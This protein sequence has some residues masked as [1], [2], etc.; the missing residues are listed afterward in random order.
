[1]KKYLPIFLLLLAQAVVGQTTFMKLYQKNGQIIKLP[2]N[3]IDSSTFAVES[4]VSLPNLFTW[5]VENIGFESA[6][7]GGVIFDNG[8]A[9]IL[10]YGVCWSKNPNPTY[11]DSKQSYPIT[12]ETIGLNIDTFY[13]TISEALEPNTTYFLRAFAVNSAGIDYGN[14]LSFK[15]LEFN[16]GSVN[17]TISAIYLSLFDYATV[18]G[19]GTMHDAFGQKAIDLANDL[20]GN[21][22]VVHSLG[23][24]WFNADYNYSGWLRESGVN[25]R[26]SITWRYYYEIIKDVNRLL[27]YITKYSAAITQKQLEGE[28]YALRAYAYFGLINNFQQTFKGNENAKGV[29]LYTLFGE[30]YKG[31]GTARDVYTQ[32]TND[33]IKAESLL[34]GSIRINK[35]RIDVSVVRGLRAR[36]ALAMENY[37]MAAIYANQARQGYSLMTNASYTSRSGFSSIQNAEWMWGALIPAEQA[38][39]FA[40]FFSHLDV[41][42]NGYARFGAQKKITKWLYDRIPAGDIRKN[43]FQ[44]PGTGTDILPDYAQTKFSVPVV[45]SWA[46]DYLFMRA[47]EMYLIEAEALARQG[48]DVN[49]RNVLEQLVKP[50]FPSYS[51]ASFSG[52][53][54]INEILLQRR[55]E[56]WGEG[57]SLFDIK[58]TRTGLNRPTGEGNHGLPNLNPVVL[59]LPDASPQFLMRIPLEEI[60]NNPKM[61]PTDQNP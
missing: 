42:Q 55:I 38:T 18:V 45:G 39:I 19:G 27:G 11:N 17:S 30:D 37:S 51:A 26:S 2:V 52:I 15:T 47:A 40:S 49:A 16:D 32:I 21:D 44:T 54:L 23:F 28:C 53:N 4:N 1:M 60:Q 59:T 41:A 56:L 31:R 36:V 5:Q 3:V 22:M 8:G 14:T 29:P 46:A 48:Q 20:M 35:N 43:V 50:R 10:E 61:I 33:L 25:T 57:F 9:P 58:R 7:S 12:S 6:N 13:L 24:G 34:D